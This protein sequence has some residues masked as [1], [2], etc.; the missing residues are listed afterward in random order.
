MIYEPGRFDKIALEPL[1]KR[2][3]HE[4]YL[5]SNDPK[6]MFFE[7]SQF[8]DEIGIFGGLV[9]PLGFTQP[10]GGSEYAA[11]HVL[12]DHTYCCQL[13]ADI[14]AVGEPSLERAI[15]CR[16]WHQKR[17]NTRAED[18]RRYSI[19]LFISE[20]GN[21]GD[22]DTC[23]NEVTSVMDS[24]DENLAGWAYWQYK[25]GFIIS[26]KPSTGPEGFFNEDGSVQ[27]KKVKALTRTY[28][29]A[30][31]GTLL[32]MNFQNQTAFFTATFAVNT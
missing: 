3:F 19:P 26:P 15:D 13:S 24:C 18:A 7:P 25:N 28:L 5:A 6:L 12:N 29:Q 30:T 10:P 9:F 16:D 14:C 21:C 20:F 31:Q 2:A 32:R 4:A 8:P 27:T 1:F 11:N 17:I 22:T 23:V